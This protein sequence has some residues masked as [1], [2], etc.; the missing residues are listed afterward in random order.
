MA[1][2]SIDDQA[3]FSNQDMVFKT[4]MD[5]EEVRNYA[6][7]DIHSGGDGEIFI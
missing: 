5:D 6:L 1:C 3:I 4:L 7:I 2:C